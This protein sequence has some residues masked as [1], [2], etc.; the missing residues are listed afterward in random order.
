[1]TEHPFKQIRASKGLSQRAVAEFCDVTPQVVLKTEQGLYG[2]PPAGVIRVL[3]EAWGTPE[4]DLCRAYYSWQTL[5]RLESRER[6][7]GVV[8]DLRRAGVRS[9]SHKTWR[10]MLGCESV[11]AYCKLLCLHGFIVTRFES[12]GGSKD[13]LKVA[14]DDILRE[15]EVTWILSRITK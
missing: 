7:A 2:T 3:S 14:L 13:F 6:I 4:S 15:E 11:M 5:H 8:S 12:K 1:M 10:R 9:I